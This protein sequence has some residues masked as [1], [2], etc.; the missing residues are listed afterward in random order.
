MT[1]NLKPEV[2]PLVLEVLRD[3]KQTTR[4]LVRAVGNERCFCIEG[5]VCEAYRR[6]HPTEARWTR[7]GSSLVEFFDTGAD[8]PY[9]GSMP[10]TVMKWALL[11]GTARLIFNNRP[12]M[13]LN[14]TYGWG[15]DIFI[16]ELTE[17]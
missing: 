4:R 14:D 6:A 17:A 9:A 11:E 1:H 10:D 5:A 16:K 7:L 8:G 13:E 2:V 3:S 12:A 15:F